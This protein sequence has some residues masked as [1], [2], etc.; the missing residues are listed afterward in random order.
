[1]RRFRPILKRAYR[2][3]PKPK[4]SSLRYELIL[5]GAVRVYRD[6]LGSV[7]REVCQDNAAGYREYKRRIE[8]MWRRQERKCG[9]CGE[10]LFLRDATFDHSRRRGMSAAFRDDRVENG[11][12]AHWIC[13]S[14]KG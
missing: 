6:A 14:E 13:N 3:T 12:A 10:P 8:I 5:N 2:W 1:M 11:C 4:E 7:V 9:L